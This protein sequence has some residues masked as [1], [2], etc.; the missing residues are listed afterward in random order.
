MHE[1]NKYYFTN[2]GSIYYGQEDFGNGLYDDHLIIIPPHRIQEYFNLGISGQGMEI[3]K[4]Y[5]WVIRRNSVVDII[6]HTDQKFPQISIEPWYT[7]EVSKYLFVFGA[8]ASAFG[9]KGEKKNDIIHP[10]LGNELF[11]DRY[12]SLYNE[13]AGVK[14]SLHYLKEEGIDIETLF[15]EEWMEIES[16]ANENLI[17]RHISIQLY[18]SKLLRTASLNFCHN[19]IGKTHFEPLFDYLSRKRISN[20]PKSNNL[21]SKSDYQYTFVS[22]N[23]DTILEHYISQYFRVSFNSINDYCKGSKTDFN[24]FKPHGSH[25]WGWKFRNQE[26]L[27]DS[28]AS[29]LFNNGVNYYDLYFNL[30]GTP[31]T[32]IDSLSFGQNL[33]LDENNLGR[34]SVNM[35]RMEVFH[36]GNSN[37]YFP[38]LL[39]PYKGKDEF[40]MPSRAFWG[41]ESK[42]AEAEKVIIIGWKGSEDG[43]NKI[44]AQK[45]NKIREVIICDPNHEQVIENLNTFFEKHDKVVIKKYRDF[46]DF[47]KTGMRKEIL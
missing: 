32:M 1:L 9:M 13:F 3:I 31:E 23:Q 34:F 37:S 30:L 7:D 25:N 14:L 10:P 22:F 33:R 47:V 26:P 15:E 18:I 11:H 44:L 27:K 21:N 2:Y 16:Y 43:F 5:A 20:L 12:Q 45:G 40:V 46:E 36:R 8:G 42:I 24:F 35:N 6:S 4:K 28:L 29:D 39:I 38:S 41:M 19:Y 17:Q